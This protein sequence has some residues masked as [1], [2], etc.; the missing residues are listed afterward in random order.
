MLNYQIIDNS[1]TIKFIRIVFKT[2]ENEYIWQLNNQKK[3][4]IYR[5]FFG[6]VITKV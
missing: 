6:L 4:K 2:L 5:F 3:F 1:L